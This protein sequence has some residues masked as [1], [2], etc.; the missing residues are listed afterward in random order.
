M[1]RLYCV[2]VMGSGVVEITSEMITVKACLIV[3]DV[4]VNFA[5]GTCEAV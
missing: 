5:Q 4:E 2:Y 1:T 3:V